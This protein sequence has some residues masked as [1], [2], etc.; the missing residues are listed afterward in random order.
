MKSKWD[1]GGWDGVPKL[2]TSFGLLKVIEFM[3]NYNFETLSGNEFEIL[4]RDLLQQE[5]N[6]VLESFKSG[7]DNGIDLRYALSKGNFLIVQ[8]KHYVGSGITKL[9]SDLKKHEASKVKKLAPQ[10]YIVVTSVGLSPSNKDEIS[11]LFSPFTSPSDIYGRDDLNNLLARNPKVE[12]SHYKLWL[13]STAVL[14]ALIKSAT[15]NRTRLDLERIHGKIKFYVA[16]TDTPPPPT[17][18]LC[19]AMPSTSNP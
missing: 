19:R 15:I 1:G 11:K 2:I 10:R 14:D 6:I 4:A 5:L 18:M 13:S 7:R 3:P 17:L 8:C 16:H 12:L 9:I